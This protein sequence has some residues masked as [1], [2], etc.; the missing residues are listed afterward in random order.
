MKEIPIPNQSKKKCIY[1]GGRYFTPTVM[2][3]NDWV[4]NSQASVNGYHCHTC[5]RDIF[6]CDIVKLNVPLR[7]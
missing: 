7:V 3:V 2:N 5:G 6:Q 4:T 1:C